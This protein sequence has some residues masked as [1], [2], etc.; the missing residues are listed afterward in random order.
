MR[1]AT[2]VMII[3]VQNLIMCRKSYQARDCCPQKGLPA[4]L[5][6]S[7]H[8]GT[9]IWEEDPPPP[10][11]MKRL[12][13]PKLFTLPSQ[14]LEFWYVPGTG[15]LCG[16]IPEKPLGP[17]SLMNFHGRRFT[18]AVTTQLEELEVFCVTPL[19]K[20]SRKL[21]PGFFWISPC[22]TF[23]LADFTLCLF[24]NKL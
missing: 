24:Y 9:W 10:V 14:S 3:R 19:G 5:A 12:V 20:H 16:Q 22:V 18:H 8:L 23:P 17:E 2:V 1:K 13:V 4:R 21:E 11:L 7:W 15:C 6:L